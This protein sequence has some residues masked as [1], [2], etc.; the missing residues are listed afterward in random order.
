[1]PLKTGS[2]F[3]LGRSLLRERSF[4]CIMM[5]GLFQAANSFEII[6]L[7]N[8]DNSQGMLKV[9]ETGCIKKRRRLITSLKIVDGSKW[10]LYIFYFF[11][12]YERDYRG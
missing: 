5:S 9:H 6:K 11:F 7:K 2:T 3:L 12:M 8:A 1:M 4:Y 10:A